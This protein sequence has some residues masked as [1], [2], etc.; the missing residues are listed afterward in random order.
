[1]SLN[2]PVRQPA[3]S[4]SDPAIDQRGAHGWRAGALSTAIALAMNLIVLVIGSAAGADMLVQ[5]PGA[6]EAT[7][8]GPISVILTTI[9]PIA[10]ATGLLVAMRKRAPASLARAGRDRPGRGRSLDRA[11]APGDRERQHEDH[12]RRHASDHRRR[13]VRRRAPAAGVMAGRA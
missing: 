4:E 8:V 1:M 12:P 5:P 10:L 13:L 2:Q 6:D 11:A 3:A 9:V 7:T